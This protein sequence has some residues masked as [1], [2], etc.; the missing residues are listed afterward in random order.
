MYNDNETEVNTENT[1]VKVE[2]KQPEA[3]KVIKT[4]AISLFDNSS[5]EEEGSMFESKPKT[6]KETNNKTVKKASLFSESDSDK[7]DATKK[8]KAAS[9]EQAKSNETTKTT[10]ALPKIDSDSS[11]DIDFLKKPPQL[12][13]KKSSAPAVKNEFDSFY[14]SE[15]V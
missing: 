5:D 14:L 13:P 11:D 10:K 6:V 3:K 7:E 2:D 4:N 12:E 8:A 15:N 1:T 9:N